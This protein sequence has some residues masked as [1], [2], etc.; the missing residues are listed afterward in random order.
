M[1]AIC[2][3]EGCGLP[4][5][6]RGH[7]QTHYEY[8]RCRGAFA[9]LPV[10]VPPMTRYESYVDR[11][12]GL[13]ECHPWT[14]TLNEYGYGQIRVEGRMWLAHRWAY[15][16]L[17]GA[18]TKK[19]VVR[20]S[21]DNPACQNLRHMLKGSQADNVRDRQERGRGRWSHGDTHHSAK[22]TAADIVTIRQSSEPTSEL[23]RRYGVSRSTM[24]AARRG[25][26]WK[27]LGE[28]VAA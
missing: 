1:S 5:K 10:G 6:V 20:H 25:D 16:Q 28:V 19:E 11:A 12:A 7:C 21:C 22:L 3:R 2:A 14:G 15:V 13:D 23:A 26:T 8:A 17:V 4:A 27:H 24:S 18:L 9:G